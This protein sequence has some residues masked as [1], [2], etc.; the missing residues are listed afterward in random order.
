MTRH[1]EITTT[2]AV[3]AMLAACGGGGQMMVTKNTETSQASSVDTSEEFTGQKITVAVLDFESNTT[4]ENKEDFEDL[5]LGLTDMFIT[6]L[7]RIKEFRGIER[8]QSNG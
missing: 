4:G 2:L 3:I 5:K 1:F 7:T 6:D 8:T